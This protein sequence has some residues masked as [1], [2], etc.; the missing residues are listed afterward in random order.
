MEQIS[1]AIGKFFMAIIAAVLLT[2]L[3]GYIFSKFWLW[4]IVSTFDADPIRIVEAIG[5]S[6]VVGFITDGALK[7]IDRTSTL[8]KEKLLVRI[9]TIAVA[10]LLTWGLGWILNQFM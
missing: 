5:L 2:L 6:F 1:A 9:L 4:F 8:D 10:Y 7:V 3:R